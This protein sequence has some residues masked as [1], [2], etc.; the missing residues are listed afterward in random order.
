[1]K[2]DICCMVLIGAILLAGCQGKNSV[3]EEQELISRNTEAEEKAEQNIQ[4]EEETLEAKIE[5]ATHGCLVVQEGETMSLDGIDVTVNDVTVTRK[6]G[7]WYDG[8]W[9]ELDENGE[10]PEDMTYVVVNVTI[11]R[12]SDSDKFWLNHFRLAYF[13]EDDLRIGPIEL[14]GTS[15]FKEDNG[16]PD[17]YEGV[18]KPGETLTTDLIFYIMKEEAGEDAHFL[19][20]Y[21]PTGCGIDYVKP[22]EYCMCYLESLENVWNKIDSLE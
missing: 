2:K 4:S 8:E 11:E 1:M 22:E 13:L 6:K 10:M 12:A 15:L 19:L 20:L 21:N 14:Y 7:D 17:K 18:V 16:D 9:F 5:L 3:N